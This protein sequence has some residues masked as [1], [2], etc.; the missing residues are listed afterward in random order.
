MIMA[1][2]ADFVPQ[3]NPEQMASLGRRLFATFGEYEKDRKEL[4]DQWLKNL[5]Q[6]RGVYDP[7][8]EKNIPDDRSK[9]YPKITRTKVV[10][11]VARLMEMLFPQTDKNFKIDPSPLPTLS[12]ADLQKVLDAVSAAAEGGDVTDEMI[13]RGIWEF[14]KAKAERLT[15]EVEDQLDEIDYVTL[16]RGVVFSAVLYGPGILKGPMVIETEGRT[17]KKDPYTGML[18][19][20]TVRK[21]QPFFEK[22][23]V[24]D[25]YPD[26]S[27]KSLA[28]MDGSFQRHVMSR[29]QLLALTKRPDFIK[30]KL[31]KWLADNSNGNFKERHWEQ[32]LRVRGDRT[33]LTNL[34]GRKYEVLEYWG[35]VTGHDLSACGVNVP[36]EKLGAEIECNIW[37]IDNTIVKATLHPYDEKANM[38]HVFIYEEDDINLLGVGLPVVIRDSQLAIAEASR[39]ILDNGS[40]VCG[41]MLEIDPSIL[42]PGQSLDIHAYKVWLRDL[43]A[44]PNQRA[45]QPVAVDAHLTELVSIVELFMSFA[46]TETALPPPALGDMS[47][48]G[49]EPYRT[50]S[51]TSMLLGAAALPIRDT[52]RNYDKFTVSFVSAV[53]AWN[54]EFNPNEKIKGDYTVVPRAS[55]SLV[56]KEVRGV[57]LDQF[58]VTLTPDE[59]VYLSTKKTLMER[60]KVR[61]LPLDILEDDKI[62]NEKLAENARNAQAAAAAQDAV[63]KAEIRTQVAGAFKDLMLG[64][65]AQAGA[66][67]DTFNAIVEGLVN[68]SAANEGARE[69]ARTAKPAVSASKRAGVEGAG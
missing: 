5:R 49:K 63:L 13:E 4:E 22:V 44:D 1:D 47:K 21:R 2:T 14:A 53:V 18:T 61:D 55:T 34:S 51:G 48:S 46:D 42:M 25:W 59:K 17:W 58:L 67:A 39:M 31:E 6:F 28:S 41:P 57:N 23:P 65:K 9:A 32:A 38:Y 27:A 19:A 35:R 8:I 16:A 36:Q 60:M 62:V 68:V 7:D 30:E 43:G 52:V 26:L 56:A 33:N 15:L 3:V 11:T 54:M 29:A 12:Q 37:M 69:G 66:N 40:A 50:S 24:W 20:T 45:V 10:G 64:L